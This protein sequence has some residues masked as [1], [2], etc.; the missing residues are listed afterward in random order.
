MTGLRICLFDVASVKAVSLA[1][2]GALAG[3][4]GIRYAGG[5]ASG[6]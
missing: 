4:T 1:E 3:G 5:V 6:G 2:I